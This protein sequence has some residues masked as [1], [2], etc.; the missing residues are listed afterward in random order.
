MSLPHTWQV[1]FVFNFSDRMLHGVYLATSNGQENISLT[2]WRD[3][4]PKPKRELGAPSDGQPADS[5]PPPPLSESPFPAQCMFEIVEE[6]LPVPEAEFKHVLEYTERQRF[7][8][9]LSHWQVRP[10]RARGHGRRRWP[11][12]SSSAGL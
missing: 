9:K 11:A 8:F 4:G 12:F 6:F 1:I 2:A 7:K 10:R 3:S 5:P